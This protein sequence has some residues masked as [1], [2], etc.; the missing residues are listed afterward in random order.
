MQLADFDSVNRDLS[1]VM[2]HYRN[3]GNRRKYN[4]LQETTQLFSKKEHDK[5]NVAFIYFPSAQ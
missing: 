3:M 1:K 5:K 2:H 4:L